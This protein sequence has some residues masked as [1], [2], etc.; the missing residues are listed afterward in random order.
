[1]F[2]FDLLS[3]EMKTVKKK[4]KAHFICKSHWTPHL[5][6]IW[7]A[8][9]EIIIIERELER[10]E[11]KEVAARQKL[12]PHPGIFKKDTK[13]TLATRAAVSFEIRTG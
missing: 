11:K 5:L 12:L 4:K 13:Y 8:Q 9:N 1:M 10:N 3:T 7:V 6:Q 2:R